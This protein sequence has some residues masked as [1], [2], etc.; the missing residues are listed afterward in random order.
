MYF[1]KL[2]ADLRLEVNDDNSVTFRGWYSDAG[3]QT[4]D[5]LQIFNSTQGGHQSPAK[6]RV[7]AYDFKSLVARF[8]EAQVGD[9]GSNR[10]SVMTGLLEAHLASSD[11]AALGGD[12]AAAY[13]ER[14]DLAG[15]NL[16]AAQDVLTSPRFGTEAQTLR[17]WNR[18]ATKQ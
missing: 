10:W 13:A 18:S 6:P 16:S 17:P 1:R 7:D 11:S 4:L 2:N 14:G 15:M 5:T 9:P 12:L 3:N 8:N